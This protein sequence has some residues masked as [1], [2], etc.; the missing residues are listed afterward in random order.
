MGNL[1]EGIQNLPADA[2]GRGVLG[3]KV[4]I[5]LLQKDQLVHVTIEFRVRHRRVI[6]D[7]VLVGPTFELFGQLGHAGFGF[8]MVHQA[9][10]P[11]ERRRESIL[12]FDRR[13]LSPTASK[14]TTMIFASMILVTTPSPN[15]S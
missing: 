10:P 12:C 15:F 11:A 4:G 2:L 9:I 5:L 1:L 8:F 13:V 14:C 7:I 3:T 6:E